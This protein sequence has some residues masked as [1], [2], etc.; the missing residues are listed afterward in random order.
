M[1][2]FGKT[3]FD[4]IQLV[5]HQLL[6]FMPWLIA[7]GV[8]SL[9]GAFLKRPKVKGVLGEWAMDRALLN[10]LDSAEYRVLHDLLLPDGKGGQT[11][12]D[13]VIV[14]A[15]GV[16]VIETKNWDCWV[17]GTDK[18][19]QWTLSYR[20]RMKNKTLNPLHQNEGHVKAVCALLGVR[21]EHCHNLVFIHPVSQLKC[22]PIPGVLQRGMP[23]HIRSFGESVF[24]PA[25]VQTATNQLIA[26]SKSDDRQAVAA[27]LVQVKAKQRPRYA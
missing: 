4:P 25:W 15:F 22:G 12:I 9:L 8:L 19:S 18:D 23:D 21:R 11:Q 14:S 13:H 26:A 2:L 27:H 1:L 16:F 17:F 10:G 3:A 20:G 7:L 24:N 5:S 6:A